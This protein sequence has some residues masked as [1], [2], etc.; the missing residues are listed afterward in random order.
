MRKQIAVTLLGLA[1]LCFSSTG[2]AQS[3]PVKIFNAGKKV[4]KVTG[5]ALGKTATQISSAAK[6]ARL[7]E[8]LKQRALETS[9]KA[10]GKDI[11]KMSSTEVERWREALAN[12]VKYAF[13]NNVRPYELYPNAMDG[14]TRESLGYYMI[15]KD[16][17]E[18]RKLAPEQVLKGQQMK[19]LVRTPGFMEKIRVAVPAGQEAKWLVTQIKPD[20]QYLLL[21]E[22]H[23]SK[24]VKTIIADVLGE[25]RSAKQFANRKIF[26]FSEFY[27]QGAVLPTREG[28]IL[29]LPDTMND[30]RSV[31]IKLKYPVFQKAWD[32]NI[33]AIGLEPD[34]VTGK[35]IWATNQVESARLRNKEWLKTILQ[36]REQYPDALFV[37]YAGQGHTN[38]DEPYSLGDFFAGEKTFVAAVEWMDWRKL[39]EL[40]LSDEE[41]T[42]AISQKYPGDEVDPDVIDREIQALQEE[43]AQKNRI[44]RIEDP[45][46]ARVMGFDARIFVEK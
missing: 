23:W 10:A 27:R 15:I 20:T 17:L 29:K 9:L 28:E 11:S 36:Y 2:W 19:E 6:Q 25:I 34:F 14:L 18:D 24:N 42:A 43:I 7:T 37:I 13:P 3:K 12:R 16:N 32:M 26:L 35:D 33:T 30:L 1:V 8:Q 46:E 31:L 45:Q 4:T 5:D 38:Y 44:L 21:G 22:T 41:I 40:S 39:N